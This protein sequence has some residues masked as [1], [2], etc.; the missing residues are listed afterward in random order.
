MLPPAMMRIFILLIGLVWASL[1]LVS[2]GGH[3]EAQSKPA[4]LAAAA[5]RVS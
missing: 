4:P 5:D 1:L 2:W 3:S